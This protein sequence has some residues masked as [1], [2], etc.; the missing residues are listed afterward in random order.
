MQLSEEGRY[1]EALRPAQRAL[2]LVKRANGPDDPLTAKVMSDL[3]A[4]YFQLGRYDECLLLQKQAATILLNTD[5]PD[6]HLHYQRA[7]ILNNLGKTHRRLEQFEL[8]RK[9]FRHALEKSEQIQTLEAIPDARGNVQLASLNGL[10]TL[11]LSE[12]QYNTSADYAEQATQVGESL[13]RPDMR[14]LANAH[15]NLGAALL[16]A[17]KLVQA[18][19]PL[20]KGLEINEQFLRPGH[21]LLA[22]MLNNL[23]NLYQNLERYDDASAYLE[24]SIRIQ[25]QSLGAQHPDIATALNN[26]GD[27]YR[28][29]RQYDRAEQAF[30]RVLDIYTSTLGKSHSYVGRTLNN[31]AVV[32]SDQ[33]H[34]SKS[35]E[36]HERALKIEAAALGD[37][38]PSVLLS[39]KNVATSYSDLGRHAEADDMYARVLQGY[40]NAYGDEH[41]FIM[42]ALRDHAESK[43]LRNKSDEA[44]ALLRR[45]THIYQS[46][47]TLLNQDNDKESLRRQKELRPVFISHLGAISDV[48]A[49]RHADNSSLIPESFEVGQL[50]HASSTAAAVAQMAVRYGADDSALGKLVREQQ[51]TNKQWQQLNERYTEILKT[52]ADERD[53]ALANK[54]RKELQMSGQRIRAIGARIQQDFP[55]YAELTSPRPVALAEFQNLL[56]TDDALVSYV[57]GNQHSYVWVIT[58]SQAAMY[59]LDINRRGIESAVTTLRDAVDPYSP[60]GIGNFDHRL[61]HDLYQRIFLP[62]EQH[63]DGIRHVFVV[64]DGA[65]QSLPPA[66]LVSAKPVDGQPPAWLIKNYA[67]TVLPSASTLKALKRFAGKSHAAKPFSGIGDPLLNGHPG[68]HRGAKLPAMFDERGIADV[69]TVRTLAPLPETANEL[70]TMATIL[71]AGNEELRLRK[72]ATESRIKQADL[73]AY[74]VLAFATHGLVA[75]DLEQIQEPALVLTPPASGTRA[76]DGLLTASEIARLNLNADL[77]ILSACNTAATDGS[78]GADGLSGLTKAF[79][80]AGSRSLLVSH[81]P[82]ASEPTVQLTTGLLQSAKSSGLRDNAEALRQSMLHLMARPGY[83]HP[84]FWAPFVM[85]GQSRR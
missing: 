80:Y 1:E 14:L 63:L 44:L 10:A 65:L 52:P 20:R 25:E 8:A 34:S 51:E 6:P 72:Q 41:P 5:S 59:R 42:L 40:E 11:A 66:L 67:F 7:T 43:R 78:P 37:S 27:I 38:H 9:L 26:L 61:A 53:D 24:R 32:Y 18:E 83:E 76:D 13:A 77:V 28:L 35:L 4:F 39:M 64:A 16:S 62:V 55:G 15:N 79:I 74:R 31:L 58:R 85:V 46:T 3:A 47:A 36:Y 48:I 29:A 33:G 49:K 23:G 21:P 71:G 82:V 81:W 68:A 12:G 22:P 17:G 50:A 30:Q 84:V 19:A 54:L 57:I 45:A 56:K 69:D 60:S 73:S 70:K 2:D 75:G